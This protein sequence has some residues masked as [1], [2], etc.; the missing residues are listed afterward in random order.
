MFGFRDNIEERVRS[1]QPQPS[2]M[3]S[4]Q[5]CLSWNDFERN[6]SVAFQDLRKENDF[7]DVTLACKDGQLEAHKVILSSC[8]TFFKEILKKNKHTHP[9]IY[10]KDVKLSQLQAIADFMYQGRVNVEQKELDA[11]LA[12]ARELQMKGLIENESVEE[13]QVE[14]KNPVEKKKMENQLDLR[15]HLKLRKPEDLFKPMVL[16]NDPNAN[17]KHQEDDGASDTTC[18]CLGGVRCLCGPCE[19]EVHKTEF[20]KELLSESEGQANGVNLQRGADYGREHHVTMRQFCKNWNRGKRCAGERDGE[21]CWHRHRCS[22][23]MTDR[24]VCEEDHREIDHDF[25]LA[26]HPEMFQ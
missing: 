12:L 15:Q 16:S 20:Y 14:E 18:S 5:L 9:L 1:P 19:N 24:V 23:R 17:E 7:F 25:H 6:F 22:K 2:Q 26:H 13:N 10:M 3:G 4:E 21:M 8:S 11:F